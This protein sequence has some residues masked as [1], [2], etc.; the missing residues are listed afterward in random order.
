MIIRISKLQVFFLLRYKPM[1]PTLPLIHLHSLLLQH[2]LQFASWS[3]S[4]RST[5]LSCVD[6]CS[7]D[8]GGCSLRCDCHCLLPWRLHHNRVYNRS[9]RRVIRQS[10]YR[11]DWCMY[12][13]LNITW[14]VKNNANVLWIL[15]VVLKNRF[16]EHSTFPVWIPYLV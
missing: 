11:C 16:E 7:S 2:S 4:S 10:G 3:D 8:V 1:M 12:S 13:F 15:K 9:V 14:I 5:F 6:R